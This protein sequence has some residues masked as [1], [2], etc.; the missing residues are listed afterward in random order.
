MGY[1]RCGRCKSKYYSECFCKTSPAWWIPTRF[2]EK[3]RCLIGVCKFKGTC[4]T[5]DEGPF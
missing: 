1:W 4:N 2:T 5:C 3:I